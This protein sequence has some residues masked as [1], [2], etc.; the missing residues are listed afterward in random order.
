MTTGTQDALAKTL[1]TQ[2]EFTNSIFGR[3]TEGV[4]HARS[5]ESPAAG[6]NCMNWVAGHIV[7]T[8]NSLLDLL[9]AERIWSPEEGAAYDRGSEGLRDG[10]SPKDFAAIRDAMERSHE[11]TRAAI[12]ALTPEQLLAPLPEDR[13]PFQVDN[14]G[15]MI[16]V[17]AFHE[18]Y[19]VGQL[20][21]LRRT[22]GLPGVIK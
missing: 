18:S 21:I 11:R 16:A 13:N 20:G 12:A 10:S 14:L 5:L 19:H 4:D 6:G 3:T 9:G 1:G 15:E 17:A 8:R 2:F 7:R 22:L